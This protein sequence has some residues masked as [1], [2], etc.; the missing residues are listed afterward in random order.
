MAAALQYLQQN[1]LL[2]YKDLEAKTNSTV[3]QYHSIGEKIKTTESAMKQNAEL[4][5]AALDYF[6]TNKTFDEYKKKRYSEKYL[7][8][9]EAEIAIYRAAQTK[10]RSI[11]QGERLPKMETL[12]T[13]WQTL[14]TA[15]KYGYQDYRAAQK[16]M[17][18]IITV[19]A[20]VDHLLGI[21]EREQNKEKE[22]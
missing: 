22:R 17:R 7:A 15:K 13:E 19:K 3:E 21:L 1:T 16:N 5:S 14:A 18:E 6:R 2:A 11:L 12:R 10:M 8:E 20:N 4:K 9:H